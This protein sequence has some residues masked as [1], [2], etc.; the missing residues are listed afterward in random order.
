MAV[1]EPPKVCRVCVR[2]C[3]RVC[4][5]VRERK[6]VRERIVCACVTENVCERE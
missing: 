6:C 4:E 1:S 2:A 3:V 5:R